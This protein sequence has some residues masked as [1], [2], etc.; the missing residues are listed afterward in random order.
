M[1]IGGHDDM[2]LELFRSSGSTEEKREL[3]EMLVMTGSDEVLDI[4]DQILET[5]E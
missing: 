1:M 2:M 4:I 5:G 3:L